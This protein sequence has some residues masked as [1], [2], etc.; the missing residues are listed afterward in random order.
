MTKEQRIDIKA[1]IKRSIVHIARI[2]NISEEEVTSILIDD[3]NDED[4]FT[5][6]QWPDIQAFMDIEGFDENACLAND[7]YFLDIYGSSAYFVNKNWLNKI[8]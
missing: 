2:H 6:I 5:I 4:D 8:S 3:F 1:D 7:D